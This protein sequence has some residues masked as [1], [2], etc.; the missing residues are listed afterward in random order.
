[1]PTDRSATKGV[2]LVLLV[3]LLGAGLGAAGMRCWG[4]RFWWPAMSAAARRDKFIR[5]LSRELSL[6]PDQQQQ[7]TSIVDDTMAKMHNL[8]Q[9]HQP[10]YDDV[11]H[12]ARDRIRAILTP[13]QKPKFEDFVRRMDE[14][15]KKRQAFAPP[16]H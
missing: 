13:E 7:V 5:S 3:F 16:R 14:E 9:Q 1:M 11:R 6:T 12:Q 2:L 15:R 4:Q 10:E 8:D